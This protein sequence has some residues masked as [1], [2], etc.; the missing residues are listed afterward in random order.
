MNVSFLKETSWDEV[1]KA[2]QEKESSRLEWQETAK[3]KGFETWEAWRSVWV[4][5]IGAKDR[6]WSLYEIE[7]PIEALPE[8]LVGPTQSW[9]KPFKDELKLNSTFMALLGKMPMQANKKISS[10]IEDFPVS[11]QFIGIKLADGRHMLLEGHHRAAALTLAK[12][13]NM[14]LK[15]PG[16]V[17]LALTQFKPGEEQLLQ[18]MLERGS[19]MR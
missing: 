9:Q 16:K 7:D 14:D 3:M 6:S 18:K 19:K 2:W 17:T 10:I 15:V 11:T 12:N 4:E 13:Q 5:Q 8:F 1:F